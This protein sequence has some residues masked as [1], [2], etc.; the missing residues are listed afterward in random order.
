MPTQAEEAAKKKAEKEAVKAAEKAAVSHLCR[1]F[2]TCD[3]I[4][5]Y[6]SWR[7]SGDSKSYDYHVESFQLLPMR[8][9]AWPY[10]ELRAQFKNVFLTFGLSL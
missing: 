2:R 3:P 9:N 6:T 1:R 8:S 4:G 10:V 5:F 7:T